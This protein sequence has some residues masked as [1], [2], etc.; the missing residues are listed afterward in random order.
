MVAHGHVGHARGEG[1][2][3]VAITQVRGGREQHR[4]LG[5]VDPVHPAARDNL[6]TFPFAAAQVQVAEL[7]H[8][9]RLQVQTK[10]AGGNALRV[11]APLLAGNTQRPEQLLRRKVRH[12]HAGL[13]GQDGAQQ[14][15]VAAAV[16][17]GR[18]RRLRHRAVQHKL[19]PVRAAQHLEQG[20]RPLVRQRLLPVQA[21]GHVEQVLHRHRLFP[22][23]HM[24]DSAVCKKFQH[25]A[26]GA[27]QLALLDGDARQCCHHSLGG[28]I[29]LVPHARKNK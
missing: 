24:G 23:V 29:E 25:R 5:L 9:A 7:G 8:V 27:R 4:H 3:L 10:P 2:P 19:H 1:P 26:I 11:F 14:L 28:R 15:R 16:V 18:A 6:L 21:G 20:V 12:G 13:A 22:V 17:E